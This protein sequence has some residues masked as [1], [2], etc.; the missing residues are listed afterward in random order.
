MS[1][2]QMTANPSSGRIR[3]YSLHEYVEAE[4]QGLI[5]TPYEP[6]SARQYVENIRAGECV[7]G[8]LEA[9]AAILHHEF[10]TPPK[11]IADTLERL[12]SE[13]AAPR[14]DDWQYHMDSVAEIVDF[15]TRQKRVKEEK[16][17]SQPEVTSHISATRADQVEQKPVEWIWPN[18]IAFGKMT[19]LGGDPGMG[20]SQI[21]I[22]VIARITRGAEWPDGGRAPIGN[23]VILSA[24]DAANDTICPRL[25]LAGAD[26]SRV[27]IINAVTDKDGAVR[28]FNL[29]RDLNLL[30]E[31]FQQIGKVTLLCIDPIT[32]YLGD[33]DSHRTSDVRGVL[34]PFDK[35]AEC[36]N[37][38]AT[39]LT[40]PPK[41]AQA[42]AVNN[43]TGSLAFVANARLAFFAVEERETDRHLLLAVKNNLGRKAEGIGY[44]ISPGATGA[45]IHTSRIEWDSAPVNVTASEAI[46]EAAEVRSTRGD[47]LKAAKEFLEGYLEDRPMPTVQVEA[48][49][50]KNGVSQITLRRA[51]KE[52]GVVVEKAGMEGGWV[53]RLPG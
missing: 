53:W 10:G 22:D 23:C 51:K 16:P 39:A 30:A 18:R 14:D 41:A 42:K 6:H 11:S 49:A 29:A 37:C 35:F 26:L 48:A 33:T 21:S 32:A 17:K 44:R 15:T 5:K 38:G 19:L 4:R 36:F 47:A 7:G 46:Q 1:F 27:H 12:L 20:K 40:H 28:S 45:G 31:L 13:P 50:R 8:S 9:Y 3:I 24:E 43:F 34:A 52:L 25:T 2:N